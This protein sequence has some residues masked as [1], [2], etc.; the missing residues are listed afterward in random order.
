MVTRL[1]STLLTNTSQ[2]QRNT[3]FHTAQE[4]LKLMATTSLEV[5]TLSFSEIDDLPNGIE[6][7]RDHHSVKR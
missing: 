4:G 2:Y 6:V 3:L 7:L 1:D 5:A